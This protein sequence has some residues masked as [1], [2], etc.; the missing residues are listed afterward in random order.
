[1]KFS[2]FKRTTF[3]T[4]IVVD[5]EKFK[6]S[7]IDMSLGRIEYPNS[8]QMY[9]VRGFFFFFFFKYYY[10]HMHKIIEIFR[11]EITLYK[12]ILSANT[13]KINFIFVNFIE[14]LNREKLS[15]RN[16]VKL[17]YFAKIQ[18]KRDINKNTF[19]SIDKKK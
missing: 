18:S 13:L 17:P 15:I 19:Q 16:Q 6:I 11:H 9:L 1:M 10:F 7:E 2:L 14:Q 8:H 5:L 12:L 3:R 4:N